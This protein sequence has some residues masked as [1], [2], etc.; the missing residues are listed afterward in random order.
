MNY[1][2]YLLFIYIYIAFSD[3]KLAPSEIEVIKANLNRHFDSDK[4]FDE[5]FNN[6]LSYNHSLEKREIEKIIARESKN[7]TGEQIDI[8]R[9][10]NDLEEIM[11][12]DGVVYDTE[13]ASYNRVKSILV[14]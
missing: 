6:I 13:I 10:L 11:E 14:K 1:K 5:I 3:Y 2:E 7:L 8:R 9:I 12:S 4:Q